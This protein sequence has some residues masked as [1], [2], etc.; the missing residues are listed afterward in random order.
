MRK[1]LLITAFFAA[2]VVMSLAFT[3]D[4]RLYKNLK[5]L[6]KNITK[7][8]MDSVMRHFTTSL[9]VKCNFCHQYNEETKSMDWASDANKHKDVARSMMRMTTKI[10]KKYFNVSGKQSLDTK[11]LVTCYT[12]HNG[13]A[14]PAVKAPH[15]EQR[16]GPPPPPPTGPRPNG[17]T[18]KQQP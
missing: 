9:G 13:Q 11:L 6:P 2:M 8:Q 14:D 15:Q 18:T 3:A 17:D 7:P 12:C 16:Q 5:V 10:N 4:E 1:S